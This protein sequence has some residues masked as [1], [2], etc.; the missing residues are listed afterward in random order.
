MPIG[1]GVV[2]SWSRGVS[3]RSDLIASFNIPDKRSNA[4][5]LIARENLHRKTRIGMRSEVPGR[6]E[7]LRASE[8][9]SLVVQHG[10]VWSMRILDMFP[11]IG[12]CAC[13]CVHM[14]VP[15][16]PRPKR[17]LRGS[18][19]LI[20]RD[21]GLSNESGFSARFTVPGFKRQNILR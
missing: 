2:E 14:C 21:R 4:R 1:S 15:G 5:S 19:R 18:P 7:G 16:P 17:T 11:S 10:S 20:M 13:V 3:I 8:G 6:V 9:D 12:V